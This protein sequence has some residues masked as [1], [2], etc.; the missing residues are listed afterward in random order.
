MKLIP[1]MIDYSSKW[2]SND[3]LLFTANQTVKRDGTLVM[4]AGNAKA[5][6]DT[7]IGIDRVFG[8][9]LGDKRLHIV[10]Y[11][12]TNIGALATKQNFKDPSNYEFVVESLRELY[13]SAM[14]KT[15]M[16]YHVPYPAIGF[17]GLTRKQLDPIMKHLPDNVLVYINPKKY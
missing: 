15:H 8:R 3:I 9:H 5:V 1:K 14:K 13:R 10:C 7:F 6:R 2:A 11:K 12:G 17:G 16:T 4:G